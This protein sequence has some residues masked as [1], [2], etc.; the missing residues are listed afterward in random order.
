MHLLS[1]CSYWIPKE[2]SYDIRIIV[3]AEYFSYKDNLEFLAVN[4]L[5][6]KVLL[7]RTIIDAHK[8]NLSIL[9]GINNYF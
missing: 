2:E 9:V 6:T 3:G 5:E 1:I 7:K 4:I 8:G